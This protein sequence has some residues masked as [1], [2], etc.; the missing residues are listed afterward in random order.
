MLL[1][2]PWCR[3]N[4]AYRVDKIEILPFNRHDLI[5][6][7]DDSAQCSVNAIM[8]MHKTIEGQSVDRAALVCYENKSP[9]DALTEEEIETVHELVALACFCGLSK[10][11]YFGIGTYCNSDCFALYIQNFDRADFTA[12]TTRRRAGRIGSGW[13]IDDIAITIPTHC[14]TIQG[15]T[16]D[17][18]LLEALVVHR[19]KTNND[20]W[21]RWQNAITCFNQ[22]NTDSDNVRYQVEWVLLCSALEHLLGAKSNAKDVARKLDDAMVPNNPLLA[23]NA[24]RRSDKLKKEKSLR[25]EWMK[26]FYQIRGDFAHGNL[27]TQKPAVWNPLE[28]LVLA[29]IAFPL[30][31]KCLLKKAGAY[32]LTNIDQTQIDGFEKFADTDN[33][34][35]PPPDRTNSIDS[36]WGRLT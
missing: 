26:E 6:G 22:A 23:S 17:G 15:V 1:L 30:V 28:H 27:N 8:A 19:K 12:I 7:L 2:M 34:L 11:E 33:F 13:D 3:I 31:V 10:R 24:N 14:H 16:L 21:A 32:E 5:D 20:E 4:K 18:A 29:T 9:I 35:K 25:Y 36:H